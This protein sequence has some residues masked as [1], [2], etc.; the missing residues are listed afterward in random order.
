M[1]KKMLPGLLLLACACLNARAKDGAK[2]LYFGG[3]GE[4]S[5][6]R[7]KS[8]A[9]T[10]GGAP[11]IDASRNVNRRADY[12]PPQNRPKPKHL[13][14]M[15]TVFLVEEKGET[16]KA[17]PNTIFRAGDVIQ[18]A[19]RPN[20]AGYVYVVNVGSTGTQTV[21]YPR[22]QE[23]QT[24]VEP[25]KDYLVPARMRFDSNP[26]TE[27]LV[28]VLSP[29]RRESVQVVTD[30]KRMITVFTD[31]QADHRASNIQ[32]ADNRDAVM[33][34]KSYVLS[35]SSGDKDLLL[36]DSD[37]PLVAVS[38]RPVVAQQSKNRPLVLNLKLKHH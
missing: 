25:F 14:I 26:G 19:L 33:K 8:P 1:N 34:T 35:D 37:G 17:S 4:L 32:L 11:S 28:V 24:L 30:D 18:L 36:D 3:S 21:I 20:H 29:D 15:A 6:V 13:G 10:T 9:L 31:S 27:Q 38:A 12:E 2:E 23:D 22:K 7:Q 5:I 16:R